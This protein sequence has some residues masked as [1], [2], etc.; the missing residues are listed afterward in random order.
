MKGKRDW[1][2]TDTSS[3][4]AQSTETSSTWARPEGPTH[5]ASE[6]CERSRC[7]SLSHVL[8]DSNGGEERTFSEGRKADLEYFV[9][10]ELW[11][12]NTVQETGTPFSFY[13]TSIFFFSFL[14]TKIWEHQTPAGLKSSD[15]N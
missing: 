8:S 12:V 2:S 13:K 14:V 5:R 15:L 7:L 9:R 6:R 11:R 3:T 10:Y 4:R 1:Q